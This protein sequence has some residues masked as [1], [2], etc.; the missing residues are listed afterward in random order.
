MDRFIRLETHGAHD[1]SLALERRRFIREPFQVS[2][3]LGMVH[4]AI[5]VQR[6]A[7]LHVVFRASSSLDDPTQARGVGT[8]G[9]RKVFVAHPLEV[10]DHGR[11]GYLIVLE[12]RRVFDGMTTRNLPP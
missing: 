2:R 5:G 10:G 6:A 7:K 12:R 1:Q 11:L 9:P 3:G 4:P 8:H